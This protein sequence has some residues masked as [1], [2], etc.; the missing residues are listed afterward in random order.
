MSKKKK[1]NA[2]LGCIE[3]VKKTNDPLQWT[4]YKQDRSNNG[5]ESKK[6]GF[7]NETRKAR[8]SG[9]RRNALKTEKWKA[10]ITAANEVT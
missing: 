7:A 2:P 4:S 1:K 3:K 5:T 9:G 10:R 8:I 6:K